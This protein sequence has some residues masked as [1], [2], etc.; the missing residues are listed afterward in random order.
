MGIRAASPTQRELPLSNQTR[1]SS[2]T[3]NFLNKHRRALLVGTALTAG[4][5]A[6]LGSTMPASAQFTCSLFPE[7]AKANGGAAAAGAGD[8][9]CGDNAK[10]TG[11]GI[12]GATAVGSTTKATGA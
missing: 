6:S 7:A 11:N 5:I 2:M 3:G 4:V 8:F 1:F 12:D 10:A 9:A